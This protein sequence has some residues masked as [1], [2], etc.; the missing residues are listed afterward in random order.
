MIGLFWGSSFGA[1]Q[2][3]GRVLADQEILQ[4][5]LSL[6]QGKVNLINE[7]IYGRILRGAND[8]DFTTLTSD[9]GRN[10]V[11]LMDSNGLS[12]T[13][14]NDSQIP[15]LE[16]IGYTRQYIQDLKSK[17]V[18]FKLV[19]LKGSDKVLPATWENLGHYLN[20][21]YGPNHNVS[22]LF[23][24]YFA[25]LKSRSFEELKSKFKQDVQVNVT[26]QNL[27]KRATLW[28][29]RSFLYDE[30]RLTELY[31][32]DGFTRTPDG[33]R[34]LAEYFVVNQKIES[35]GAHELIDLNP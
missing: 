16:R 26:S 27:G 8:S 34:G 31:A 25:Q 20:V 11:M 10:I 12:A 6:R 21:V 14:N 9:K 30:L 2:S 15:P 3:C 22:Q 35:L 28:R 24:K 19:L 13:F 17:G 32:G 4:A 33:E 23:S 1:S 7:N 18:K 29:F 5:A